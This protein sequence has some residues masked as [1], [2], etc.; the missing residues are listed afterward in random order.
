MR[1]PVKNTSYLLI[2]MQILTGVVLVKLGHGVF[3]AVFV[4]IIIVL[5]APIASASYTVKNLNVTMTLN[6]NTSAHVIETLQVVISNASVSQYSTNRVALNL[7]LSNWQALIGP[8]LSTAHNKPQRKHLQ[9]QV[10][11]RSHSKPER[12]ACSQHNTCL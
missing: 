12:P 2:D 11:A 4:S 5:A 1:A 7:T 9:F 8:L 6:P 3:L 10:P